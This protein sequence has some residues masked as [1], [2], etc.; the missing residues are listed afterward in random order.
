MH[1]VE[2]TN[3]LIKSFAWH[4]ETGSRIALVHVDKEVGRFHGEANQGVFHCGFDREALKAILKM[5]SF[6]NIDFMIAHHF[7][8]DGREFRHF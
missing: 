1:H 7:E 3:K 8:W 2:D 6:E 5:H 4:L